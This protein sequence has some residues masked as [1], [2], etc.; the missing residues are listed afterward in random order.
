DKYRI[1][2]VIGTGGMGVVVEAWHLG[3]DER[4]A[5]KFLLPQAGTDDE[6]LARFEREARTAFK[7][8]SEHV[9][10]VIDVGK[11]D[12]KTANATERIPFMVMEYLQG[13]DLGEVLTARKGLAIEDAVD[14]ILQA[15]DAV[16]EAH[17]LGIL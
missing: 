9:C 1:E 4:V 13:R 8:K 12:A 16:A 15:C 3:F 5:I 17:V 14:W 11:L 6:A 10:R 7:I 2:R